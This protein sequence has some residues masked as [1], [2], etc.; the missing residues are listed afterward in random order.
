M[1]QK[2]ETSN[3]Q[4]SVIKNALAMA[5]E[6]IYNAGLNETTDGRE[7]LFWIEKAETI[8]ILK[9]KIIPGKIEAAKGRKKIKM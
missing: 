7:S 3:A 1:P 9:E 2:A 4:S 8:L 5:R 6:T